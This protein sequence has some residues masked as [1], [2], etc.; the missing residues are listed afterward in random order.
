MLAGKLID[1]PLKVLGRHLVEGAFMRSLQHTPKTLNAVGVGHAIDKLGYAVLD[2]LVGIG[3][4]FISLGIIGIDN[5]IGI[6]D[7]INEFLQGFLL[8]IGND[9]GN[10]LIRFTALGTD[11][12]SHVNGTPAGK[13]GPFGIGLVFPFSPEKGFVNLHR[14]IKGIARIASPRFPDAVH[15]EPGTGLADSQVPVQF[16]AGY[17]LEGCDAEINGNGPLPQ[18]DSGILHRR[19]CAD[20]EI[21]SAGCAPIRHFPVT[22]RLG[23]NAPAF[24]TGSV[25]QWPETILKPFNC[26]LLG[27]KHVH[28]LNKG[29]T[30][31]VGFSGCFL[32][33]KSPNSIMVTI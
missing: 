16:H 31:S 6:R 29:K 8:G 27:G 25:S 9:L 1:I 26:G 24:W 2:G 30:F 28:H 12:R 10:N 3:N 32:H 17:R 23:V 18:G 4:T 33:F 14:T 13:F 11:H 15:H 21:G 19:S 7:I 22:G 5:R 20:A